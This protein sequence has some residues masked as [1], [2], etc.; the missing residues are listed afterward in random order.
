MNETELTKLAERIARIERYI[1][2]TASVE[3]N[4]M[5]VPGQMEELR[6]LLSEIAGPPLVGVAY[7]TPPTQTQRTE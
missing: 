7:T 1:L 6:R 5:H 3:Q 4:P 2:L